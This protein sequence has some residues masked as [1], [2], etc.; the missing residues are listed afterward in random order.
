MKTLGKQGNASGS[1][2]TEH[3]LEAKAMRMQGSGHDRKQKAQGRHRLRGEAAADA[4]HKL[5]WVWSGR[6]SHSTGHALA[7]NLCGCTVSCL[8][9]FQ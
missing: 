2:I 3:G 8:N 1:G 7:I 6:S 9:A 4:Q 5:D